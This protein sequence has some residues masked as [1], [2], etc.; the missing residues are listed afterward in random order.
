MI[1]LSPSQFGSDVNSVDS[2]YTLLSDITPEQ[3]TLNLEN[4]GFIKP[5]G[6]MALVLASRRIAK[7]SGYPVRLTNLDVNLLKYLERVNF[8]EAAEN[9]IEL[10]GNLPVERWNRNPQT[11]NLL[12][13]TP[14]ATR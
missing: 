6:I 5:M 7:Q 12:E 3:Y 13:L 9:W 14:I 4:A 11:K 1:Q 10:D 2:L 8:F